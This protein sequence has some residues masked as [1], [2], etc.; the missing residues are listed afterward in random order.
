MIL[1]DKP[2]VSDFM[3]KT[4]ADQNIPV[5][6]TPEAERFDLGDGV[7]VIPQ[8]TAIRE[9]KR[10]VNGLLYTNSENSIN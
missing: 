2:Y 8:D 5:I 1:I 10:G 7:S 4:L 3:K 6:Q 9:L